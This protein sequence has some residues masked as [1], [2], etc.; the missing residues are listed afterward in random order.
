MNTKSSVS[1]NTCVGLRQSFF[2]RVD[3]RVGFCVQVFVKDEQW[4]ESLKQH[5]YGVMTI[6]IRPSLVV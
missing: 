4:K 1:N 5:V 2:D 3:N 6:F